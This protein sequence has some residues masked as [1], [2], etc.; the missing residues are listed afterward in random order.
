MNRLASTNTVARLDGPRCQE[1]GNLLAARPIKVAVQRMNEISP[2]DDVVLS[3]AVR[4]LSCVNHGVSQLNQVVDLL[5]RGRHPS[6]REDA[7][8]DEEVIYR[9][10]PRHAHSVPLVAVA[11]GRDRGSGHPF[12][13]PSWVDGQLPGRQTL[14]DPLD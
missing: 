8:P 4:N 6:E 13:P 2:L 12:G 10:G 11:L 14:V 5:H 3:K 1:R 7:D 9:F